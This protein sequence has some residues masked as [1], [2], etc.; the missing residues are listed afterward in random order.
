[1]RKLEE[2][3][4]KTLM[5]FASVFIVGS[6]FLLVST[7][8]IKGLPGLNLDLISKT[9]GGGFYMGGEG[10][11]LN[12]ILGSLYIALGS[13]F[14]ALVFS[15]PIVLYLNVYIKKSSRLGNVARLS[16][17][18]L[19]GIPSIVYGAFGFTLMIYFG[20]KASLMGGIIA[21]TLLVL[22]VMI[23][24]MDEVMRRVPKELL[25]ASFSLG[26]TRLE[27]SKI[28][29]RQ[30]VPGILTAILLSFGRAIGDVASVMFTAGFSDNIP[31]GLSSPAPSLP[32]AI[33]FQLS[34][35]IEEVQSRAY[36]SAMILTVIVL[37][38]S[39]AARTISKRF[40]KNRI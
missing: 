33:F 12:A 14:L 17:D 4:F 23:R 30:S 2:L 32:L 8:F 9:P 40:S 3:F 24:T 28:L 20:L 7:I 15:L 1:M 16:S 6:F 5:I 13:S 27:A 25:D 38:I 26:A 19:F 22:P 18:V 11:V 37:L 29:L 10:G 36:A 39:V 35:P 34:S 31:T 21:V